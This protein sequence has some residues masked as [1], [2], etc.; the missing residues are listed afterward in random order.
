ML[1][2]A[3]RQ[4]HAREHREDMSQ[5]E[6]KL[7]SQKV[8]VDKCGRERLVLVPRRRFG[9]NRDRR[10]VHVRTEEDC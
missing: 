3:Q 6:K 4:G 9:G 7:E 5:V 8:N 1:Q 2:W 10:R